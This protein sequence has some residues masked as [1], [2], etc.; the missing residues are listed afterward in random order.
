MP[1]LPPSRPLPG[2]RAPGGKVRPRVVAG[3]LAAVAVVAL[4]GCSSADDTAG[5]GSTSTSSGTTSSASTGSTGSTGSTS[6]SS[7]GS[8]SDVQTLTV[9]VNGTKVTPAPARVDL[10]QGATLRLFVTVDHDDELH[11]HG[12]DVEKEV[13]AGQPVT[14]DL[15]GAEPGLYEVE[16]HHPELRL[17]QVLVR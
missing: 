15:T 3:V 1:A 2:R 12:F 7:A 6:R 17:L 8:P 13:T 4:S 16:L 14:V 9:T 10:A 11:A 5:A